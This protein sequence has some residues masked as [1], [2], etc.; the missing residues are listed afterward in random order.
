MGNSKFFM[1][2]LINFCKRYAQAFLGKLESTYG[3]LD[4]FPQGF[5]I[6]LLNL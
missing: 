6:S 4:K 3:N 1:G 2:I 5:G